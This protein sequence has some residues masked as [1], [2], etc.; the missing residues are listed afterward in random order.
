MALV[1]WLMALGTG[2]TIHVV[3]QPAAP[4]VVAERPTPVWY[5]PSSRPPRQVASQEPV[6]ERPAERPR[7]EP[8][9]SRPSRPARPAPVASAPKPARPIKPSDVRPGKVAERPK[10]AREPVKVRTVRDVGSRGV[11]ESPVHDE[12][13]QHSRAHDAKR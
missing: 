1:G 8:R 10:P 6:A 7:V 4:V 11:S 5:E 13:D 2:C 12:D 9:P 3:E